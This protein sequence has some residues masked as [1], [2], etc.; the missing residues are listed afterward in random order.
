MEFQTARAAVRRIPDGARVIL[1][2]GCVEPAAVYAALQA[3]R[4]RFR[5]L[6]LYSGL[7][8]GT[9][10]YLAEG[11]G[12]NFTYTT[13]QASGKIR[14]AMR[15]GRIDFVPLRF[16]E[17]LDVV[18][19]AGTI[20]PDV[21]VI[22]VA[23]PV[24]GR[25]NL[26]ISVSLYQELTRTAGLVIAEIHPD[27]PR[28]PGEAEIPVERIDIAVEAAAP[29]GEY[30]APRRTARDEA[31]ADRVLERI[32]RGAW[33]QIGVGA[34]PDL[35]L[36]RLHEVEGVNLH[37]G[38]LSDGVVEF[39]ERSRHDVRV[40]TGE[41]CGTPHLYRWIENAPGVELRPTPLTHGLASL[42]RLPRF[43][44]VN[45]AVEVDLTGQING[46]VVGGV[47]MSGIGGSL[48][49]VEGAAASA[50]GV[51]ILALASTTENG[52]H[53]KIVPHLATGTPVTIPRVCA[54]VVVSEFGVAELR[55]RTLRERR[56]ALLAI[57]HPDF[58]D[59]LQATAG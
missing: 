37:S 25:V 16:R 17:V 13:W 47:Q 42:A 4:G 20:P 34:I 2:H 52:A 21:L 23:P 24:H 9:Y 27:M 7:Q 53:S 48:D 32:P 57:A 38:M 33:V 28:S 51:S 55:G 18:S 10:S 56:D 54:D 59:A 44:S 40:V 39:V 30:A 5:S 8:F 11:L 46:E 35:V 22:Q 29:L 26:G 43:V 41:I 12:E 58:R 3:E 49:F 6:R 36:S 1:P 31:I 45:S 19:P 15:S 50:G 14:E